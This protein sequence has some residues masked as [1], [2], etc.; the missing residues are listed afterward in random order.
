MDGQEYLNQITAAARPMKKSRSGI[1]GSPIFKVAIIGV[2][3]FILIV[4]IGSFLGGSQTGGKNQAISLKLHIDK[5]LAVISKYQPSVKSSTLRSSSA[6]LYSVLSNTSRDLTNVMTS[7]YKDY[8]PGKEDPKLINTADLEQDALD[9]SL[10]DAK[11]NGVLDKVYANKMAYEISLIATMEAN[12]YDSTNNE[13]LMDI[14]S[15]SY[16][17]LNNLYASFNDFSSTK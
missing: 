6:S 7:I 1:L 5:T 10:S 17:S 9:S 14:L 11:I 3:L 13:A 12:L 8:K 15:T 2:V 4:I 16:D